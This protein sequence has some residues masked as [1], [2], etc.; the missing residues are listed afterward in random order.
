MNGSVAPLEP[1]AA[2]LAGLLCTRLCHDLL[3]P[4]GAVANGL[5]LLAEESDPEMRQRCFGLLEQS[6]R[7]SSDKL[8]FFR[9]AFGGGGSPDE[10]VP[11]DEARA[12]LERLAGDGGRIALD[13]AVAD[14]T[15]PRAAVKVLLNLALIGIEAL[16]RGGTLAIGAESGDAAPSEI[17]VRAAGPRLVFDPAI[18]QALDG[19]L[20]D[21]EL[22]T[23]T[24]PAALLRR[25]VAGLG[26]ELQY[27][28]DDDALMLGAV[29]PA[30]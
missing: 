3:S 26:G 5:E 28:L 11:V 12:A 1:D 9:L 17:V 4:I 23:R 19:E 29:L 20:A 27:A 25:L 10:A 24:V 18:G 22:S 6:A 13:W 30:G 8:Q 21:A 14:A 15:L 16:V 2:D 7:A